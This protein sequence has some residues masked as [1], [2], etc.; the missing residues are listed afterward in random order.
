M[1]T[2]TISAGL[3][4]QAARVSTGLFPCEVAAVRRR[5]P[6][7]WLPVPQQ[8]R[9]SVGN[10]QRLGGKGSARRTGGSFDAAALTR[11]LLLLLVVAGAALAVG[12]G[13]S[14]LVD[15]VQNWAILGAG[16]HRLA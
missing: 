7:E 11:K 9:D 13:F 12:Y 3:S 10:A 2:L 1:N 6:A 8:R 5:A 15:V 14:H 16:I 4:G